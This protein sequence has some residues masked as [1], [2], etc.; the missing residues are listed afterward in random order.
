MAL[1]LSHGPFNGYSLFFTNVLT[2]NLVNLAE[3]LASL[4]Q[5]HG[6]SFP[7]SFTIFVSSLSYPFS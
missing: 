6:W 3:V 5:H 1:N 2:I 7:V 4:K